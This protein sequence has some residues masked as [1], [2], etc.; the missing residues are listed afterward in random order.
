MMLGVC[1]AHIG[2][3]LRNSIRLSVQY[4]RYG[5]GPTTHKAKWS[6]DFIAGSIVK[7]YPKAVGQIPND[8]EI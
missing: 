7:V 4:L 5:T 6:A 1:Y 8:T 2:N 3:D